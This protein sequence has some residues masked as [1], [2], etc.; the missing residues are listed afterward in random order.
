MRER[1]EATMRRLKAKVEQAKAARASKEHDEKDSSPSRVSADARDSSV[2][3]TAVAED[4]GLRRAMGSRGGP[5]L[6]ETSTKILS[7]GKVLVRE[8]GVAGGFA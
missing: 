6:L 4:G 1:G 2:P 3:P 5:K 8:R 7:K